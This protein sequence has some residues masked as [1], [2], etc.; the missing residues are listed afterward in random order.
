MAE[1]FSQLVRPSQI[2]NYFQNGEYRR[3]AD[4]SLVLTNSRSLSFAVAK[5]PTECT[6]DNRWGCPCWSKEA[7]RE[8]QLGG[9]TLDTL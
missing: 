5:N 2:D 1:P 9:T 3:N 8:P 6:P 7:I 4:L